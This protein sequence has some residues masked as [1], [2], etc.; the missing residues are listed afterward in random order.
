MT[1]TCG[2]G[3]T[4]S[5]TPT[6]TA[7]GAGA[8]APCVGASLTAPRAPSGPRHQDRPLRNTPSPVA[9]GTGASTGPQVR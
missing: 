5:L 3:A 9:Q 4:K 1:G 2:S 8:W 7:A 6:A